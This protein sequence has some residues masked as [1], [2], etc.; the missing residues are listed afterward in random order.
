M[1]FVKIVYNPMSMSISYEG[2]GGFQ[3]KYYSWGAALVCIDYFIRV[4]SGCKIRKAEKPKL[5]R[6]AFYKNEKGSR[7]SK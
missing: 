6:N 5:E 4:V 3:V 1:K 7:S 2:R